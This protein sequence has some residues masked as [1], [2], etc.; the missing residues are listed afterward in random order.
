MRGRAVADCKKAHGALR[1]G[2][3]GLLLAVDSTAE[4]GM[5]HQEVARWM[6]GQRGRSGAP[7]LGPVRSPPLAPQRESHQG[8]I[9][10]PAAAPL[11]AAEDGELH[12]SFTKLEAGD[13]WPSVIKGHEVDVA[14]QQAEQ[15]RLMLERFQR[16]VGV[17]MCRMGFRV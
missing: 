8:P 9:A 10:P 14:T 1:L 6:L 3:A 13:P 16:E 2:G 4:S 5:Q 7:P 11:P 15:Q 12:V 17:C